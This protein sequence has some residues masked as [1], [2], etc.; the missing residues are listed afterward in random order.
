MTQEKIQKLQSLI[1]KNGLDGWLFYD[2]R[3]SNDLAL[4]VLEISP[5]AHLTRRFFYFIPAEGVPHKVAM[6]I[7]LH[8]LAHLPGELHPY[9]SRTSLEEIIGSLLRGVK[10]IA[11]EYSPMNAIPY[12]SKLDAGTYEYLKKFGV[13]IVSSGDLLTEFT[14]VW[15]REQ[16]EDNIPVAHALT[17][18]VDICWKF[19]KDKINNEGGTNEYE[20]QKLIMHEIERRGFVTDHEVIVG[21][22][23]NGANPHYSPTPEVWD[24][25]KK[26]DFVLLDLWAKPN[27]ENGVWADITWTGFVGTEVPERYVKIFNI[28][29]D[30]REAAFNLVSERFANG[31]ELRGWEVD[32]AARKVIEDAGYGEYFVHRTGH[33]ITTD[34]HGTG[35]HNDNYETKDMR[36]ILPGTSFSIEPGIYLTGDFGVRSEI[37]VYIHPD[38]RVEQ[39]GG[40]RQWEVVPI[41][42]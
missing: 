36:L 12:L 25:I 28:V 27:K 16:Y 37:D 42:K 17:D 6:A 39:T 9:S 13:E 26:D 33:S 20:V 19:I 14:A 1:K 2:F 3:G 40:E 8:N 35:P 21:V 38:G 22:N 4:S 31:E 29:R 23:G 41:L 24:L 7:E 30:A 32:A 15:S 5:K 18:I 34:L 11:M 10:K